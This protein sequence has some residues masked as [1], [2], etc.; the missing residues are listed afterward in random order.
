MGWHISEYTQLK[1]FLQYDPSL[2]V[3]LLVECLIIG[4]N[5]RTAVGP[6]KHQICLLTFQAHDQTSLLNVTFES[7]F[8][9]RLKTTAG[10]T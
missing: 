2:S 9:A 4:S 1:Q 7:I 10:L 8:S 3:I 5:F 6:I